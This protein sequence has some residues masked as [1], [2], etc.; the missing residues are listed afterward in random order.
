MT[1]LVDSWEE[2]GEAIAEV[3]S[4]S[5]SQVAWVWKEELCVYVSSTPNSG[6]YCFTMLTSYDGISARVEVMERL[7][8]ALYCNIK[9]DVEMLEDI[10]RALAL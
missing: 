10:I 6:Y 7:A 3:K 8:M 4:A 2:L 9:D 1:I 5:T